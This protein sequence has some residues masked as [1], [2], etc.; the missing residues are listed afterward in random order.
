MPIVDRLLEKATCQHTRDHNSQLILRTKMLKRS[1]PTL[2]QTTEVVVV[3]ER[4]DTILLGISALLLNHEL[5]LIR[6]MS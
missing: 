6:L 2:A 4:P 5:G 3:E 1:L